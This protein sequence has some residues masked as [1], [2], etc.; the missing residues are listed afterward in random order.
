MGSKR[1]K[2][3]QRLKCGCGG[4][5]FPHRRGGGACVHSIRA[6]YYVALR[7]GATRAEAE[8]QLWAHVLEL[9]K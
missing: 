2:R 7:G 9:T 1:W 4:Y 8:A 5:H 6:D 3:N